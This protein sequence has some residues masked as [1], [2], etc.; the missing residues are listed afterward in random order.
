VLT[1]LSFNIIG[2]WLR[3]FLD[4]RLKERR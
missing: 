1:V 2:D 4:P 3:D